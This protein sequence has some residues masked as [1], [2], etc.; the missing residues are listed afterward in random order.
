MLKKDIASG[1]KEQ[2]QSD[3]NRISNAAVKMRR[4]L[5]ELLELSRI[6][7]LVNPPKEVSLDDLV[8]EALALV[9]GRLDQHKVRVIVASDFPTVYVDAA[10]IREVFQNLIDNAVKFMGNQSHPV[11]EIGSR[12]D[13]EKVIVTVRDNGIGLDAKYHETI[14]GL[15][16]RLDQK[17]EGTGV[18]L[19]IVKR[20]IEVH[21]GRVWVESEGLG[22]GSTFCCILPRK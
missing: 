19:A 14:F 8:R 22:K 4:L 6:G 2:I 21:Q 10:R 9:K 7:R 1:D 20:I 12:Q 11:I 13:K 16:N 15:F 5:E 17:K 3:I 18:G